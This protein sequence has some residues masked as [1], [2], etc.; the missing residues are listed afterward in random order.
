MDG[1]IARRLRETS[2]DV[3]VIVMSGS[4]DSANNTRGEDCCHVATLTKPFSLEQL[5][6]IIER[7]VTRVA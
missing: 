6:T 7:L 1:K 3:G 2:A 4:F 5:T